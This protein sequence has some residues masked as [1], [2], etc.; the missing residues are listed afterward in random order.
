MDLWNDLSFSLCTVL[1]ICYMVATLENRKKSNI[2]VST[3]IMYYC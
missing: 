3:D 2:E 1:F